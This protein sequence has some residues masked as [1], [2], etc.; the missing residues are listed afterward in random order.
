[1]IEQLLTKEIIAPIFIVLIAVLSYILIKK[2]IVKTFM[3]T[4]KFREHKK[5]LTIMNLFINIMKYIILIVAILALLNAWGVDTKAM[6]ASLGI[7]GVVAGLALQD[8]L[9]DFLAGFSIIVDNEYDVGDNI[10]V[11]NFRGDVIELGM[12]NTKIRAYTGEVMVIAN[13]N[14]TDVINY[15]T[16][17]SRCLIDISV[18]YEDKT[19]AVVKALDEVCEEL[20]KSTDYLVSKV[21]LLGIQELAD[22]AVVYRLTALC[23]PLKDIEFKR[24][25]FMVVKEVFDKKNISI[26]YPQVVAHSVPSG[27]D[28]SE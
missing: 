10:Q 24:K 8:I 19:D 2:I 26:P 7:A 25:A 28:S 23:K 13:R 9:K 18:S 12:K 21:E 15:S 22:S 16:H 4:A 5:S 14:V 11:G 1:M 6:L 3:G 20:T 17:P 27:G